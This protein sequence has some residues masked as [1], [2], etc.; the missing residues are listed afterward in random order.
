MG[1]GSSIPAQPSAASQPAAK[2]ASQNTASQPAQP[3]P[4]APASSDV[5][6]LQEKPLINWTQEDVSTWFGSLPSELQVHKTPLLPADG[7][8]MAKWTEQ[9]LASKGI[10]ADDAAR[11]VAFRELAVSRAPSAAAGGA[12][13]GAPGPA[14]GTSAALGPLPALPVKPTAAAPVD[15]PAAQAAASGASA[16]ASAPLSA[17]GPAPAAAPA[18][19][20][21]KR[22]QEAQAD[23]TSLT[24]RVLQGIDPTRIEVAAVGPKL[25]FPGNV[26]A[27]LLVRLLERLSA[28]DT[29]AAAA[30]VKG[31]LLWERPVALLDVLASCMQELPPPAYKRIA[32]DLC[33]VLEDLLSYVDAYGGAAGLPALL[34]P[35]GGEQQHF[36]GLLEALEGARKAAMAAL[37]V[38]SDVRLQ[39][40]QDAVERARPDAMDGAAAARE[41]VVRARGLAAVAGDRGLV[42]AVLGA[43]G[44]CGPAV[45]VEEA[46]A[47]LACRGAGS[48]AAGRPAPQSAIRRHDLALFWARHCSA[49]ETQVPWRVWWEAFPAK[50]GEGGAGAVPAGDVAAIAELVSSDSARTNF[51]INV[52]ERNKGTV[53]VYELDEAFPPAAGEGGDAA[54]LV[55]LVRAA[56]EG[57]GSVRRRTMG[58]RCLL[59]PLPVGYVGREEEAAALETALGAEPD[60][61]AAAPA[62]SGCVVLLGG[63]GAGKSTLA[64]DVGWRLKAAGKLIGGALWVD[65]RGA[66]SAG[67]VDARFAAALGMETEMYGPP[68]RVV[69]AIR[70]ATSYGGHAV[71]VLVVVDHAEDALAAPD[72]AEALR[73]VL[74][75]VALTAPGARL[76]VCSRVALGPLA[77]AAPG[78]AGHTAKGPAEFE[79]P[80]RDVEPLAPADSVRLVR[81]VAAH[82]GEGEA[83][84]VAEACRGVPLALLVVAHAL[85][86][87][88]LTLEDVIKAATKELSA[89][90]PTAAAVVLAFGALKPAT[91]ALLGQ[92]ALLRTAFS[93]AAAAAVLGVPPSRAR[94]ILAGL[95]R[96]G[97]VWRPSGRTHALHSLLRAAAGAAAAAGGQQTATEA[98]L[99]SRVLGQLREWSEGYN[100][101]CWRLGLVAAREEYPHLTLG[102]ELL[103][104]PSSAAWS[105]PQVVGALSAPLPHFAR[106]AGLP[107]R[108]GAVCENLLKKIDASPTKATP[109]HQLAVAK[110]QF[111]TARLK[112]DAKAAEADARASH[113]ARARLLGAEHPDAV[114]SLE[115]TAE[116]VYRQAGRAK[117]AEA[118]FKQAHELRQKLAAARGGGGTAAEEEE[119]EDPQAAISAAGLGDCLRLRGQWEE[120]E[121]AYNDAIGLRRRHLGDYHPDA[122]NVLAGLADNVKGE[123]RF[124]Q[125][126][127][128]YRQVLALRQQVLGTDHAETATAALALAACVNAAGRGAVA[129]PL[130][131]SALDI[132]QRLFG[133]EHA[134]TLEAL[135]ALAAC[136]GSSLGRNA[137][138]EP[139]Y[140]RA[141]KTSLLRQGRNAPQTQEWL[142]ALGTCVRAQGMTFDAEDTIEELT[143]GK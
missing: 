51:R 38:D 76:L 78:E 73:N 122:A 89:A 82:L 138:A 13:D 30:G 83:A 59:P 120:A 130:Y 43:L 69:D 71:C 63:G 42:E 85:A 72:A 5:N 2:P 88:R 136:V 62:G 79:L 44:D 25:P 115:A 58:G 45:G 66:G 126:E 49:A 7:K 91:Q 1:C 56:V 48:A 103:A 70:L 111:I 90:D 84:R 133:E 46:A 11:L 97:L 52:E 87:G 107:A 60:A 10:A 47:L 37:S 12:A 34:D 128:L 35:A 54:S 64:A 123:G 113:E 17:P 140:R 81:G 31:R 55:E 68:L 16:P 39:G 75:K 135:V 22:Q 142:K 99:V 80:E 137:E 141:L 117:E 96:L 24:M 6:A 23:D 132:R 26:A 110:L 108:L 61:T 109:E 116:A 93:D 131:R 125:A 19:A 100:T 21:Q 33:E 41:L 104:S 15:A 86:A 20:Q 18:A 4:A 74:S 14:P 101:K 98:R 118:L 27:Q 29:A 143:A 32:A 50:L 57:P 105:V 40:L 94:G 3:A 65:L 124:S 92:L 77:A 129:E 139:L 9:D 127:P 119:A 95:G 102:L 67:E 134:L 106:A 36:A 8:A 121:A 114:S 112:R 28:P 53:S